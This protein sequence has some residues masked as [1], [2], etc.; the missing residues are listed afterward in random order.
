MS[1]LHKAARRRQRQSHCCL[2]FRLLEL[3][4]TNSGLCISSRAATD[5]ETVHK[6]SEGQAR[7]AQVIAACMLSWHAVAARKAP[8]A[9]DCMRALWSPFFHKTWPHN[10]FASASSPFCLSWQRQEMAKK[11]SRSRQGSLMV[12][13]ACLLGTLEGSIVVGDVQPHLGRSRLEHLQTGTLGHPLQLCASQHGLGLTF[14]LRS[15]AKSEI[16][17]LTWKLL[18]KSWPQTSPATAKCSRKSVAR[19]KAPLRALSLVGPGELVHH[20]PVLKLGRLD[21]SIAEDVHGVCLW[22]LGSLRVLNVC[23][24]FCCLC[25]FSAGASAPASPRILETDACLPSTQ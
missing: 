9:D 10:S 16:L 24:A 18:L 6:L 23:A 22:R 21:L 1:R 12:D 2:V 17:R 13:V 7:S 15:E 20:S 4:V 25:A 3:T 14:R 5:V 19:A 11:T 8:P